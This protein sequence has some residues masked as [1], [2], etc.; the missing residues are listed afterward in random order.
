ME[1]PEERGVLVT[2]SWIPEKF[3]K[4][5]SIIDIKER[6]KW[7]NGWKVMTS[8]TRMPVSEASERSNDYRYQREASDI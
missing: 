7:V 6:G 2:T 8:G 5:G 3:A 1:K 4:V